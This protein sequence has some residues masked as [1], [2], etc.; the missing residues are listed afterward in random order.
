[1]E[2]GVPEGFLGLDIG[3]KSI[4]MNDEAIKKS[5]TIVSLQ[6]SETIYININYSLGRAILWKVRTLQEP[7]DTD[8]RTS[9]YC[10]CSLPSVSHF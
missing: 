6:Q 5:K 3:P 1:M 4:A 9:S 10:R 8:T 7:T 2:T